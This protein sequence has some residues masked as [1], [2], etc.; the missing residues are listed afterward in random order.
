MLRKRILWIIVLV[1]TPVCMGGLLPS[2]TFA[3]GQTA[4]VLE[5]ES[6]DKSSTQKQDRNANWSE[7][8]ARAFQYDYQYTEQPANVL[9]QNSSGQAQFVANPEHNLNQHTFSL[10]FSQVFVASDVDPA[11]KPETDNPVRPWKYLVSAVALKVSLAEHARAIQQTVLPGGYNVGGEADF[12]PGKVFRDFSSPDRNTGPH[13]LNYW[14]V[15]IPKVSFKKTTPFDFVKLGGQLTPTSNEKGLN[16]LEFTWDARHVL[17]RRRTVEAKEPA[18]EKICI[19]LSGAA[20]SY[21][22]VP[23]ETD[24]GGCERLAKSLGSKQFQLGCASVKGGTWGGLELADGAIDEL[25]A[26]P[27]SNECKWSVAKAESDASLQ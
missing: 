6:R 4:N 13:K 7:A 14:A 24:A 26:F 23:A 10:D 19:V 18:S 8:F 22:S 3:Q 16:T 5:G 21:I 9:V 17:R 15:A 1:I 20:R 25:K 11:K 12:D 27:A 2:F